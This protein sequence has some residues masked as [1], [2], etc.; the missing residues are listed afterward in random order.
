LRLKSSGPRRGCAQGTERTWGTAGRGGPREGAEQKKG[1]LGIGA[2]TAPTGLG[3]GRDVTHLRDL[4][5][6]LQVPH[7]R[8]LGGDAGQ[9]PPASGECSF[10]PTLPPLAS[11]LSRGGRV[12]NTSPRQDRTDGRRGGPRPAPSLGAA[13]SPGPARSGMPPSCQEAR[14]RP[15]PAPPAASPPPRCGPGRAAGADPRPLP[16]VS[17]SAALAASCRVLSAPPNLAPSLPHEPP[18]ESAHAARNLIGC[19][20]CARGAEGGVRS[21]RA[22]EGGAED[23]EAGTGTRGVGEAPRRGSRAEL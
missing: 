20:G 19:D 1:K 14:S 4:F 9:P 17:S 8:G 7:R 3:G 21:A 2:Q 11:L 12:R 5:A 22:A 18:F 6:I 13:P 16:V 15:P 23:L 10:S